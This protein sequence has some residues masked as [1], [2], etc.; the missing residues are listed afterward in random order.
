MSQDM[1]N[2]ILSNLSKVNIDVETGIVTT[3]KGTNG[4]VCKSSGYIVFKLAKRKVQLHQV[5]AVIHFG[6]KCIGM[7]V[8]HID[9]NKLNNYKSN[10]ELLSLSENAKHAHKT[11][12]CIYKNGEDVSSSK[13]NERLVLEIDAKLKMGHSQRELA[14][15]YG[16]AKGSIQNIKDRRAWKHILDS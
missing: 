13:L 1:F 2:H 6:E 14:K 16:L 10:L 4:T 8:N 9:G 5:L 3:V 15:E 12:L 11:G 7:T